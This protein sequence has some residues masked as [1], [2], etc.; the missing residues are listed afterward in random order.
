MKKSDRLKSTAPRVKVA[1][2]SRLFAVIAQDQGRVAQVVASFAEVGDIVEI[3]WFPSPEAWFSQESHQNFDAVIFYAQGVDPLAE[4]EEAQLRAS[5][6][7]TA[8]FRVAA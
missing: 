2:G 4:N 5:V 1:P 3:E 6:G 8:F 7:D